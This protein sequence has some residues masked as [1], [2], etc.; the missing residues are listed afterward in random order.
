MPSSRPLLIRPA[1]LLAALA[2]LASCGTDSSA[3][4][5]FAASAVPPA[6]GS[7]GSG[8]S[9]GSSAGGAAGTGGHA[10][11]IAGG[12]GGAGGLFGA[13]GDP[14]P[15]GGGEVAGATSSPGAGGQGAGP[16]NGGQGAGGP[17]GSS[18]KGQVSCLTGDGSQ[19]APC[20]AG[21]G[22]CLADG[23]NTCGTSDQCQ[24]VDQSF[25]FVACDGPEDC[26]GGQCCIGK[27]DYDTHCASSCD[28]QQ[29]NEVCHPGAA[30]CPG[31]AKCQ[32]IENTT[33]YAECVGGPGGG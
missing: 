20:G 18:E 17:G 7:G 22:C 9:G 8:G 23:A 27:H 33:L 24:Q 31:K 26:P 14:E 2:L 5:L 13:A 6:P 32:L 15:F 28:P 30:T 11:T 29:Q 12:Q 1:T 3:D 19:G 4:D 16:G 10:G 21:L 25:G